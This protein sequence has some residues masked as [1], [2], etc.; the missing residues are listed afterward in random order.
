MTIS[1]RAA[2]FAIRYLMRNHKYQLR[3]AVIPDG[4]HLAPELLVR[5]RKALRG[6]YPVKGE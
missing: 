6:K 1:A 5:P 4:K 2:M 3:E